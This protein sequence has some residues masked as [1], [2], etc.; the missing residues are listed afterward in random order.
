M[1]NEIITTNTI[2]E[3]GCF[4][5]ADTGHASYC[6]VTAKTA[7]AKKAI[8]NAVNSPAEK[9]RDH[10]NKTINLRHVF[11]EQCEFFDKETGDVKPGV[12]IVLMDDAGVSYGTCS[13][14]IFT[15]LSKLFSIYGTPDTWKAAVPIT[16]KQ[17]SRATNQAV[18][19][20][21]IA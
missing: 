3:E 1:A 19:V 12:R 2:S 7:E 15:G 20:F 16:I 21:E 18:L 4:M 5:I 10:I 13:N 9:L 14:G 8:F 6:S 11:A 17:I